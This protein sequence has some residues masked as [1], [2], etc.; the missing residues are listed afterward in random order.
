V[1]YFIGVVAYTRAV[2]ISLKRST[3]NLLAIH[4]NARRFPIFRG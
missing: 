2:T 1:P 3:Q 4:N